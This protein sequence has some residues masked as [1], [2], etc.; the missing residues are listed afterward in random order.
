MQ[1]TMSY[2]REQRGHGAPRLGGGG[3]GVVRQTKPS[4]PDGCFDPEDL[5]RRLLKVLEDQKAHAERR[6]WRA[7]GGCIPG[8]KTKE[9]SSSSSRHPRKEEPLKSITDNINAP[10][11]SDHPQT[12]Q[13]SSH[14]RS[15]NHASSS[16]EN[17]TAKADTQTEYHHVPREAAKQ[18]TRTTTVDKMRNNDFIQQ[19]SRRAIK[20]QTTDP[21]AASPAEVARALRHGQT[22]RDE[23]LKSPTHTSKQHTF[24]G[25][26]ARLNNNHNRASLTG[27]GHNTGGRRN[28][29]GSAAGTSGNA[30]TAETGSSQSHPTNRRSMLVLNAIPVAEEVEDI[31][32]EDEQMT[33]HHANVEPRVD[34][35]QSDESRGVQQG[36][37]QHQSSKLL[38]SPLLKKADSIFALRG[39]SKTQAAA[40]N[41]AGAAATTQSSPT[42]AGTG[43][44]GPTQA[45]TSQENVAAP[46]L[47]PGKSP[48]GGFFSKFKR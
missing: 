45:H 3:G 4:K 35:T 19:L 33:R 37:I 22:Q 14:A 20:A 13:K 29:T 18:F 34:W 40:N 6:A 47:V 30:L 48:K 43:S 23:A 8:A 12:K 44:S 25:E 38:R 31:T 21:S 2:A 15:N 28:S 17:A 9:G 24:E 39:R 10:R 46:L 7:R 42:S 41:N 5:T 27:H 36:P 1:F 26:L 32:P 16:T 11:G